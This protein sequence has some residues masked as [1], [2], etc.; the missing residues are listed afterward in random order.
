[1]V[2]SKQIDATS[3][4]LVR[5]IILY[6]IPLILSTLLQNLFNAVDTAVLGNMADSVAVASVG[7]TGSVI[8]LIITAFVGISNGVRI[9]LARFVGE[10]DPEKIT[11]TVDTS[12]ILATGSGLVVGVLGWILS[13]ML[14]ICFPLS[15]V[16]IL[17]T[18]IV[19]S[20]IVYVRFRKGKYR[21]L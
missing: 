1:M 3:G 5:Q 13:P 19:I 15:W 21:K 7:A 9:V 10:K 8:S 6:S 11:A 16:L 14:M 2:S 12:V 20:S 18:N 4:P 17:L